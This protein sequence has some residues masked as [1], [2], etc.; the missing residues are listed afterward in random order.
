MDEFDAQLAFKGDEPVA[1]L[2]F[3]L[4]CPARGKDTAII[5]TLVAT[6]AEIQRLKAEEDELEG[7]AN[8]SWSRA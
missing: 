3:G 2:G 5:Y 7:V 8:A 4:P 6:K 1:H